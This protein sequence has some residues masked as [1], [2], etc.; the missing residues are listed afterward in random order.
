MIKLA[1]F[2]S[3]P[4]LLPAMCWATQ[5]RCDWLCPMLGPAGCIAL[6]ALAATALLATLAFIQAMVTLESIRD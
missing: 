3:L 2:S 5:C 6:A 4:L 1:F